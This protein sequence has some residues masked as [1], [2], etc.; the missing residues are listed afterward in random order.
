MIVMIDKRKAS[1]EEMIIPSTAPLL[2]TG[3]KV[4]VVWKTR[5]NAEDDLVK[6][7]GGRRR[8]KGPSPLNVGALRIHPRH[9]HHHP[10][11]VLEV[12]REKGIQTKDQR[13]RISAATGARNVMHL[14]H[15]RRR[16]VMTEIENDER[17]KRKDTRQTMKGVMIV[18]KVM[19]SVNNQNKSITIHRY[20]LIL[21]RRKRPQ[22]QVQL[23]LQTLLNLR[24]QLQLN[25]N[26]KHR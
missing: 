23:I 12:G 20:R 5:I 14:L 1:G 16:L 2:Q 15:H 13:R 9:L 11:L 18:P 10:G 4:V 25:P 22:T 3:M 26:P 24:H 8:G 7:E 6:K 17:R 19:L 21:L